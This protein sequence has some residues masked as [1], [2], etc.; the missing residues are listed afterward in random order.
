MLCEL[1]KCIDGVPVSM[2][3]LG[4]SAL[5][6]VLYFLFLFLIFSFEPKSNLHHGSNPIANIIIAL[7]L[8]VAITLA[9]SGLFWAIFNT[10]VILLSILVFIV[11]TVLIGK[12][13]Y[14]VNGRRN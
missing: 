9:T 2:D 1:F 14:I 11:L 3:S 7:V 10:P 5:F 8:S 13:G 6:V 4:Y 12:L